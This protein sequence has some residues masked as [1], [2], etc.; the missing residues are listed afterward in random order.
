MAQKINTGP[1]SKWLFISGLLLS[2]NL[3][4]VFQLLG[5]DGLP[6]RAVWQAPQRQAAAAAPSVISSLSTE[7]AFCPLP[8]I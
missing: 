8:F 5:Q 1:E 3:D 6:G 2:R 4:P 7:H